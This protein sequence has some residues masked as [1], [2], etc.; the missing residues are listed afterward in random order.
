MG[1]LLGLFG[2]D[3]YAIARPLDNKFINNYLESVRRRTGQQ[4]I[5]KKGAAEQIESIAA[6]GASL[7]FIAD[8]DAGKKGIFVDFFSRKAST[9]KSIGLIAMQY[10]MPIG[11]AGCRR[12]SNRFFF[13]IECS[14]LIM[15]TEWADK[16]DPLKWVTQEYVKATEDFIR[17]DPTQYWWL[18]RRWKTRPKQ[19]RNAKK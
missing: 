18:H 16:D 7:C 3:V 2:F 9:Y 13:E 8:Q 15:P 10:N 6:A 17:K 14:R 5:D 11:V 12:V 4:I 1:Y 19:E